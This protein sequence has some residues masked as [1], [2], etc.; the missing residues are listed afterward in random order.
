MMTQG[1]RQVMSVATLAAVSGSLLLFYVLAAVSP[2]L[3][4]GQINNAGL[5]LFLLGLLALVFGLGSLVAL[6]LHRRWP[7][8]AGVRD[9]RR[10]ADPWVA[11]RQGVLLA[12]AVGVMLL[13]TLMR[14]LDIAFALVTL[15]LAG[16]IEGFF[17]NR[18][19]R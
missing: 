1:R 4:D 9:P 18:R 19:S 11:A 12:L 8:L 3:P 5:L 6:A 7:G 14:M 2:W 17:Q 16:L 10:R 15:V 13:L